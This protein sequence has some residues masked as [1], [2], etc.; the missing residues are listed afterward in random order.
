MLF[1]LE[2]ALWLF[3]IYAFL[4]WCAEVAFAA[5]TRG[6]FVNRGMANGPICPI[7]GFGMLAVLLCLEPF[8]KNFFLLF[9][10]SVLV[11]SALELV[12]GWALER[13][14]HDKWWDYTNEPFN[15]K[16]YICLR[17]SLM[18]GL[19]CLLVVNVIHPSIF[20][21]VQKLATRPGHIAL[22]VL[23]AAFLADEII[24]FSQLLRLPRQLRAIEDTQRRLRAVSDSIGSTIADGVL[25]AM[26]TEQAFRESP[27]GQELLEKE[28]RLKEK[29]AQLR[30]D[31]DDSSA[32]R[33]AELQL[34]TEKLRQQW[35]QEKADFA[36]RLEELRRLR[37]E[38]GEL[39]GQNLRLHRR[40]LRAFPALSR[41]RHREVFT[42]LRQ[43]WEDRR[44]D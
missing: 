36:R 11:T 4:G 6:I 15:L 17:F 42:R 1:T 7:Y 22:A 2:E 44:E 24:T 38:Q 37:Q 13:F 26:E 35:E 16:G 18:W 14:F 21:L 33:R 9:L 23:L 12:T 8:R 32:A 20:F 27:R 43:R 25:T 29:A 30:A 34:Q 41:G 31:L 39:L 28:A 10:G 3:L 19:A 40:L 5:L